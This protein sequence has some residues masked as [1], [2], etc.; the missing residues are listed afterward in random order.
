MPKRTRLKKK[1]KL[2]KTEKRLKK[3]AWKYPQAVMG[4]AGLGLMAIPFPPVEMLG[5]VLVFGGASY[6][7]RDIV[8]KLK[9]RGFKIN[10]IEKKKGKY[11]ITV[12]KKKK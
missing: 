6:A 8:T 7:L 1:N 12:E 11:H 3:F 2:A 4:G 5:A 9:K 10:K